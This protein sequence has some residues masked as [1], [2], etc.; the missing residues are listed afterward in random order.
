MKEKTYNS[1][2]KARMIVILI[3][4]VCFVISMVFTITETVTKENLGEREVSC[5]D[6]FE[7]EIQ[8]MTC[9]R[10]VRCGVVL[11]RFDKEYCYGEKLK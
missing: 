6:R 7:S 1:L 2:L 5:F 3:L 10:E 11:K 9:V 4:F 8:N